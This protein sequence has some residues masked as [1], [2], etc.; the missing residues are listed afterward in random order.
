MISAFWGADAVIAFAATNWLMVA[1][2]VICMVL[3]LK[4]K[5]DPILVMVLAGVMNL[6]AAAVKL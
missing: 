1:I 2:F 6:A 5:L 4:C 3:L